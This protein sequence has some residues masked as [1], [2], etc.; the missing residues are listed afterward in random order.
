MGSGKGKGRKLA[1]SW[2]QSRRFNPARLRSLPGNLGPLLSTPFSSFSFHFLRYPV[3]TF[4]PFITIDDD[5][6][7]KCARVKK[8][9]FSSAKDREFELVLY[10]LRMHGHTHLCEVFGR[11]ERKGALLRWMSREKR[12]RGPR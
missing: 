7:R 11:P 10:G 4:P 12:E 6:L 9:F 3:A 1:R 5:R 8:L 2:K